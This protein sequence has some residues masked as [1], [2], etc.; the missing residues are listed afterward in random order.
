MEI[1]STKDGK[2]YVRDTETGRLFL[3]EPL[4]FDKVGWGDIDP[5]T[6]K[7][8]GDYGQKHIGS[9]SEKNSVVTEDNGFKNIID[10]GPGES[11]FA[12]IEKLLKK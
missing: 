7:V 8:Q 2:F 11:P 3:V 12:A 1:N 6:K 9:V 5:A 10:V 4:G